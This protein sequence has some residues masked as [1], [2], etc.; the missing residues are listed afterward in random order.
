MTKYT[1]IILLGLFLA[2]AFYTYSKPVN[3]SGVNGPIVVELFTSQSCS[4]CP[5]ADQI[6]NQLSKNPNF[7]PLSFHVTYWNHLHWKDTLSRDFADIRQ[8]QYSNAKGSNRIYTPQMIING[9]KEFVGS[10]KYEA[11]KNLQAAKPVANIKTNKAGPDLIVSLPDLTND[12]YQIWLAGVKNAHTEKMTRGENRG[13]TV[14]YNNIVLSL[15][16]LETWNGKAKAISLPFKDLN[17]TA[18]V[19]HYVIF[20]QSKSNGSIK[21]ASKINL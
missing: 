13:K 4:S 12:N 5:P 18:N 9:E 2:N 17:K 16:T 20:A 14:T 21:A 15:D 6:I 10:R 3:A 7:I 19:D 1:L 11:E 8:R